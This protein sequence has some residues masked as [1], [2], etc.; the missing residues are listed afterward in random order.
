MTV[1][2]GKAVVFAGYSDVLH[3]LQLAS[4]DLAAILQN[5]EKVMRIL[6]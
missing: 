3:Q 4:H 2:W 6:I 1:T 5:K